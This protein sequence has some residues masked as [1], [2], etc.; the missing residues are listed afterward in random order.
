MQTSLN[1]GRLS[2][3]RAK[4]VFIASLVLATSFLFANPKSQQPAYALVPAGFVYGAGEEIN[5]VFDSATGRPL[6]MGDRVNFKNRVFYYPAY[7]DHPGEACA[8]EYFS[9]DTFAKLGVFV[10]GKGD[11]TTSV[12]YQGNRVCAYDGGDY[13]PTT[14]IRTYDAVTH[15]FIEKKSVP[16]VYDY[17]FHWD[18]Y[19]NFIFQT[20]A[21]FSETS[22]GPHRV[23]KI[24]IDTGR[25]ELG[26]LSFKLW[27]GAAY[28]PATKRLYVVGD[29]PGRVSV[30]DTE[31]GITEVALIDIAPY[32]G[33]R[34]RGWRFFSFSCPIA[35]NPATNRIYLIR[36]EPP[37][38]T[39]LPQYPWQPGTAYLVVIDGETNTVIE[40]HKLEGEDPLRGIVVDPRTSRVFVLVFD[41][42]AWKTKA[43]QK[44]QVF[45]DSTPETLI[46]DLQTGRYTQWFFSE[47]TT[48]PGFTMYLTL[49]SP[50]QDNKVRI[51]YLTAPDQ[52]GPYYQEVFL[53][54]NTR[55]T[56][57]VNDIT[58]PGLDIATR[59]VSVWD[60][61][62]YAERPMYYNGGEAPSQGGGI[63]AG[64]HN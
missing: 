5:G 6:L 20:D 62:F 41:P 34:G 58:G 64:I 32:I 60:R 61:P 48:R 16:K 1:K 53:P 63:G 50:D 56:I 35:V 52:P 23:A 33:I 31:G 27:C 26:S 21:Q 4:A 54:A 43:L 29:E 17:V 46:A 47:G 15:T 18:F 42:E 59:I 11:C 28:N 10:T 30:A 7:S 51:S 9:I 14:S 36:M 25:V 12:C 8:T 49:F 3:T 24:D 40:E 37:T 55:I 57:R 22:L 38:D 19:H 45:S 13:L 44:F 2:G 39:N